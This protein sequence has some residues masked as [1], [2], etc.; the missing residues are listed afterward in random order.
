MSAVLTFYMARY[1]VVRQDV[2]HLTIFADTAGVIQ[3]L[4]ELKEKNEFRNFKS[5]ILV[6]CRKFVGNRWM[7]EFGLSNTFSNILVISIE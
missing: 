4:Q 3:G 7:D 2:T 1:R 5:E 6:S